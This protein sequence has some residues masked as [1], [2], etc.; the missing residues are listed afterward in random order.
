MLVLLSDDPY[1]ASGLAC[2]EGQLVGGGD[3]QAG[4]QNQ[5][6]G[7]QGGGEQAAEYGLWIPS[8]TNSRARNPH[9]TA[10]YFIGLTAGIP[11][12]AGLHPPLHAGIPDLAGLHLPSTLCLYTFLPPLTAVSAWSM[13]SCSS[14]SGS[15]ESQSRVLSCR[16]P[17]QPGAVQVRPV[18]LKPTVSI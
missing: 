17:P 1:L 5:G 14:S 3:L 18:A 9:M 15:L 12:L 6:Q 8:F 10:P 13:A 7:L 2:D 11:D 16:G 4:A